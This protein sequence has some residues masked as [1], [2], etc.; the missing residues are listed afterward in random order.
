MFTP[1]DMDYRCS[2]LCDLGRSGSRVRVLDLKPPLALSYARN[3]KDKHPGQKRGQ[4][5]KMM[6]QV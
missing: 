5:L 4:G 3:E 1:L 2:W 6:R